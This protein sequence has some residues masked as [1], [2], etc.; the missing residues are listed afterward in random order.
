VPAQALTNVIKRSKAS[1]MMGL[2]QELKEAAASLERCAPSVR[3]LRLAALHQNCNPEHRRAVGAFCALAGAG[4]TRR[5][6]R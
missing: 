6:S 3:V 1:T 2:D 5:P 4:A